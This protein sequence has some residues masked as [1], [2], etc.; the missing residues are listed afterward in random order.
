MTR[1]NSNCKMPNENSIV[2]TVYC[3]IPNFVK[4]TEIQ[5]FVPKSHLKT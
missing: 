4:R 5:T 2:H 3:L 1:E